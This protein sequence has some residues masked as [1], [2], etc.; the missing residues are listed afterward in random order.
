MR[1]VLAIVMAVVLGGCGS[2]TPPADAAAEKD[3]EARMKAASAAERK[4][5]GKAVRNPDDE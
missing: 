5:K 4:G 3:D 1:T 2:P